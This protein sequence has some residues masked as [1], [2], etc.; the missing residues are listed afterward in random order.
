MK[1]RTRAPAHSV[2]TATALTACLG[3]CASAA[4]SQQIINF[5]QN[6]PGLPDGPVA[7]GYAGFNWG[8]AVNDPDGGGYG[9]TN[10]AASIDQFSRITPFDLD[11]VTFQNLVSEGT[12]DGS[13]AY[14]T[15]VISG[16]LGN[17]LVSSVTENYGAYSDPTFA[18]LNID[19]VNKITFSTNA[20]LQDTYCCDA[21]GN[22]VTQTNYNGPD[23]TYIS[24]LTVANVARAPEL[25][26]SS[27]ATALTLLLGS[28]AVLC[29]RRA[30]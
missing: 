23:S 2:L 20:L 11:S 6:V 25:N 3:L 28:L 26:G 29:G 18:G 15:T 10:F 21:H 12:G 19:D 5:G 9:L 1:P 22:P 17:T 13:T 8:S 7:A 27:A 16:Y 24:S 30:S 4:N 14:Y